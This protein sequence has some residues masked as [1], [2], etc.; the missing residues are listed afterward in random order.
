MTAGDMQ[1]QENAPGNMSAEEENQEDEGEK[2]DW[3]RV[4]RIYKPDSAVD[5]IVNKEAN[6]MR[7]SFN[8]RMSGIDKVAEDKQKNPAKGK[9]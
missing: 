8:M 3:D 4:G 5:F 9:K 2:I 7:E 1:S 6:R